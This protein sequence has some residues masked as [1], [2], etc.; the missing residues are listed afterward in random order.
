[1]CLMGNTELLCTQGRGSGHH[2]PARG[3]S[4]IFSRIAVETWGTFSSY[5][6]DGYSKFVFV[7]QRPDSYVV[8][9]ENSGISTRLARAIGTILEVRQETEG[10]FP[11]STVILGFLSICK[12]RQVSSPFEALNSA[13]LSRCQR[14]VRPPVQMT[15]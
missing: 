11:A 1:M 5:S 2:L 15:W 14:D 7:Q 9:R 12:K 13:R 6:G 10:H 3:K 8:T 4:H